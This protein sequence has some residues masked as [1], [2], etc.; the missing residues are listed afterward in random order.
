MAC[1]KMLGVRGGRIEMLQAQR[2]I[3]TAGEQF[4][5]FEVHFFV[6]IMNSH[7]MLIE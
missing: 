1:E 3:K 5:V 7:V 6:E 2:A 4:P